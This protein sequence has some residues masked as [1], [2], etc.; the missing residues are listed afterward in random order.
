MVQRIANWSDLRGRVRAVGDHAKHPTFTQVTLAVDDVQ[1]VEGFAAALDADARGSEV[2]VAVP[3]ETA[4]ALRLREGAT[5]ELRVRATAAGM[6]A[7]P[8]RTRVVD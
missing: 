7:H 8:D 3:R 2:D 6:F 4:A 1:P 5:V